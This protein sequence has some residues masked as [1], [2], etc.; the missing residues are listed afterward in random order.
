M[1]KIITFLGV[2]QKPATYIFRGEQYSGVV[3]AQVLRQCIGDFDE[4]LVF[5]TPAAQASTLSVLM[6]LD[7]ERIKPVDIPTGET[8]DEMWQTFIA[9][10]EVVDNGDVVTFDIT[11][12]LRSIPFLVFLAVA[13]LRS[14]KD[15]TIQGIYYG[16]LDPSKDTSGAPRPAPVVDLSEFVSLLDW[17]IASNQVI[18]LGDASELASRLRASRPSVEEMKADKEVAQQGKQLNQA[19]KALE[20]VSRSLR[21]ILPDQA[22]QASENLL[23]ALGAAAVATHRWA[24]PF[25]VLADRVAAAYAPLALP[26]PG[27]PANVVASLNRERT[28]VH[29]YL[30]RGLLVQAVALAREWLVSWVALHAGFTDL[31]NR[32]RRKAIEG[33]ITNANNER[34]QKGGAFDDYLFSS[35]RTLKGIPANVAALQLY[36]VLGN[37]RNTLLHAGKRLSLQSADSL[38]AQAIKRCQEIDTLPMPE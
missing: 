1:H 20:A 11:H 23:G 27:S 7:D 18:K 5:V 12:G 35:G 2:S 4:M 16:S 36:E 29:W 14:A 34:Q 21:L 28:M 22:M 13:F 10:T 24:R 30:D 19:A 33:V 31:N 9:V 8:P 15:V 25:T 32:E 3:F 26:S 17:L 38:E 6:E 37:V